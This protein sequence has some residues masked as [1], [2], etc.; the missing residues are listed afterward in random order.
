M[1]ADHHLAML[2][3]SGITVEHAMAR[4]YETIT[5]KR[6][7]DAQVNKV[8]PPGRNVPGLAV[9]MRR[10]DGSQWGY[11]Y[12]PDNPRLRGGK[13]VKYETP[14]GQRN[15]LDFPPGVAPRLDDPG[16]TLWIT[17]G[18]KKADCG[19]L[20]GLCI[21]ALSGVWNWLGSSTAGGK[22]AL[23]EWRDM[24]LNGR[25]VIIA[26]D[27]D[28]A[29]KES[30]QKAS[31][32]LSNYL[33]TKGARIEYLHLPDTDEKTGLDDYLMAG[34]TVED[35]WHLVK[36]YQ[37][38]P[39]DKNSEPEHAEPKP[40]PEPIVPVTLREAHTVFRR[41]LGNDYD[42]DALDAA[43][44]T[45][46]VEKFDDGSD[47][48]W[49][50]VISG[51]GAAKTETVQAFV[52]TGA[53]M[54]SSISSE[55][56][57]L[58]ATPKRERAKDAT[59]GLLRRMGDRGLLII[60]DVT[61]ILSMNNDTRARVLSALREVY[62][63][64]WDREVGAEGGRSLSWDGR[65]V[66]IGAVTT[67][68]DAAHAVIAKM[69]DRFVLV[70]ID[71]TK[72]R[73]AVGRQAISNTGDEKRMR[74]ELAAAVAGVIAGVNPEPITVT[75]AETDL[76]LA[77][78]NLVTL[79]RTSVE[80]DYR[81]DVI[82]AHAPEANTRFPKQLTQIVR[83][84]VAVGMDRNDAMR[85]AIRCARDS[86]PP[87][88][89]AIIDDLAQNSDSTPTEVRKRLG[90]PRATVDRQLQA[91]HI[92]GVA[93]QREK[94]DEGDMFGKW[95]YSL[96]VDID[97]DALWVPEKPLPEI[98]LHT[99]NPNERSQEGRGEER[100]REEGSQACTDF[101]GNGSTSTDP[102]PPRP[103]GGPSMDVHTAYRNG[104]CKSC[105]TVRYRPGGTQCEE[106]FQAERDALILLVEQLGAAPVDPEES[107]S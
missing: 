33:A 78:A 62:D 97:P 48:V 13:V 79:S 93:V 50:L 3:A 15:G 103:G 20:Q 21:V 100:E 55:A 17:E 96:A 86:M 52:G 77:A 26:F 24:A 39:Y 43:L 35:L 8:T 51:P 67:A 91:L 64:H 94:G 11:Q 105:R 45:A 12:R 14:T 59:G 10:S 42:T 72:A 5:D 71:S 54:T 66:V 75:D 22:M 25:R 9:P 63:G 60:K 90:K 57:L 73:M 19:A 7:F 47:P 88:R 107:D 27:G 92:L 69:G 31:S 1:I 18:T 81:G 30:V 99:P 70:R 29:R 36:P 87:M 41:W 61:S 85:L 104:L 74:A 82:D 38:R 23:P 46:A 89:L 84:A 6:W 28:V 58:S 49:L 32:G 40:K 16:I 4:G 56:A 65:I 68:W 101:S 98:S 95:H 37:P 44:A 2:A 106:C 80:Y 53:K 102:P 76:L 83:G 34:H